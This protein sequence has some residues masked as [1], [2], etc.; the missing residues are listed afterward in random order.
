MI[1]GYRIDSPE[2]LALQDAYREFSRE[3]NLAEK[4]SL[5]TLSMNNPELYKFLMA[6]DPNEI[7]LKDVIDQVKYELSY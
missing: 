6:D 7:N 1:A 5:G 4:S 3:M 2:Y